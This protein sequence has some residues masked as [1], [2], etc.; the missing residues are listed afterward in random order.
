LSPYS[1]TLVVEICQQSYGGALRTIALA[2]TDGIST[3]NCKAICTY[4]PVVV[5]VSRTT[6]GRLFNVSGSTVDAYNDLCHAAQ[7]CAFDIGVESLED[8]FLSKSSNRSESADYCIQ[9]LNMAEM[10]TRTFVCPKLLCAIEHPST[11]S[12]DA[13][14]FESSNEYFIAYFA[15]KVCSIVV[16]VAHSSTSVDTFSSADAW[17]SFIQSS[18]SN[19]SAIKTFQA[20]TVGETKIVLKWVHHVMV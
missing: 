19:K 17:A 11:L 9:C 15:A 12:F 10:S 16:N 7:F 1:N 3:W 18:Q 6:L 14:T 8:T 5:P 20:T 13:M 2:G 4:Q